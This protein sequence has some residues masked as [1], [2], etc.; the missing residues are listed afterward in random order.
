VIGYSSERYSPPYLWRLVRLVH[1]LIFWV[2][3]Y[4]VYVAKVFR[5]VSGVF[6]STSAVRS[7]VG[8]P[9]PYLGASYTE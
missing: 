1:I 7:L 3:G 6:A 9:S 5:N 8:V 2:P 4:S